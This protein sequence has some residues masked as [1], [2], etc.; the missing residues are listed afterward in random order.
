MNKRINRCS[1]CMITNVGAHYRYP[2]FE[3]LSTQLGVEFYLGDKVESEIKKFDYASLTGYRGLLHN[4]YWG[5][6]YW[7]HHSVGLVNKPYTHYILDGEPYCLSSWIILLWGKIR[8]KEML[9]WTHGWYGREGRVKRIV[10]KLFYSLFDKHLVYNNYAIGLMEKE[11]FDRDKMYCIANSLDS[12]QLKKMRDRLA[13]THIYRN[14]F[15]NDLPTI[16]YCGRI[17]KS[18]KLSQIIDAVAALQKDGM[19]VNVVF[20]GKDVDN[21]NIEAYARQRGID[22]VWM[23]GPCYDSERLGELYYNAAVCVSPGN[24]GLTAIHALSFGC[25]V[26]S[27]DSFPYQGPEFEAI[28]PGVTGD[29]FMQDDVSDLKEKIKLWVS[30]DEQQRHRTRVEAYKEIDKKWNI[31]YQLDTIKRAIYE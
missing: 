24:V 28:K 2:I 25:P 27:H 6:F 1:I 13:V 19:A 14:H 26:I 3:L 7:Q 21:V 4:R 5:H 10:K 22:R 8:G 11:G 12:D 17:Q 29:F 18:K 9:S 30:H 23:Y 31:H 20:V 16:I 15:G